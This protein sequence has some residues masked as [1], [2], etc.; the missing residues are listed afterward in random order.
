MFRNYWKTATVYAPVAP[1][2]KHDFPEVEQFTRVFPLLG[3]DNHLLHYKNKTLSEKEVVY[4][5]STC[6]A[7]G[8]VSGAACRS[9]ESG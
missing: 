6:V 2:M 4:A 9:R 3:V 8:G 7:Y 5:G 1:L